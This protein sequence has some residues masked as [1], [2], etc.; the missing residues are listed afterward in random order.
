MRRLEFWPDY[1]G[2]LW[3]N[4]KTIALDSLGLSADLLS[5]T[6]IWSAEFSDLKLPIDTQ[7]DAPTI[8]NTGDA[9]W[10]QRGAALLSELRSAI[11]GFGI[12]V[13]EDWWGETPTS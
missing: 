1:D 6:Q 7:G 3:E 2:L 11:P 12:V 13:T 4:G 5:R 9:L 10:L 8:G